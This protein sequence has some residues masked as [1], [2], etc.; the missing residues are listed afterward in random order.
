[1]S[2][3][4][5]VRPN[6]ASSI[7]RTSQAGTA[8]HGR[9]LLGA[10]GAS[11]AAAPDTQSSTDDW[12]A[13]TTDSL[14]TGSAVEPLQ[15]VLGSLTEIIRAERSPAERQPDH[16][17]ADDHGFALD[18]EELEGLPGIVLNTFDVDGPVWLAVEAL[19]ATEP[20]AI[21]YDLRTW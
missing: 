16:P 3:L 4:V 15:D 18:R 14:G 12:E 20:P 11:G 5:N 10:I 6:E 1:M 8:E 2:Q 9:R 7:D 19:A 13:S 17:F 21:D